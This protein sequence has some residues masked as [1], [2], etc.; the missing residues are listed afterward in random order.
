MR[1]DRV[2]GIS[3]QPDYLAGMDM[4]SDMNFDAPRL[5]VCVQG[6]AP[7]SQIENHGVAIRVGERD[8]CGVI[9]GGLLW[10]PIDNVNDNRVGNCQN[11]L[12]EDRVTLKFLSRTRVDPAACIQLFP[13]HGVAL[14]YPH[15]AIH[16]QSCAC[17]PGGITAGIR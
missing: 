13:V 6:K 1:H 3:D 7:V 4:I 15:A 8:I 17:V 2:A 12:A 14:R 10:L 9:A 11:G 5:H 16:W